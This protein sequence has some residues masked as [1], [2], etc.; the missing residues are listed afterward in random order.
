MSGKISVVINTLNEEK[1]I[2]RAV[3]SVKWADEII[4]CDMHSDDETVKIA[5]S[6]GA[7]VILHKKV[8]YV[9]PARNF[10]ISKAMG[11]WILI[12]DADEKIPESL[13]KRLQELVRKRISS[14]F[15]EIPR[16]NII[17]GKWLKHTGWWPDYHIRFFK[18]GKVVWSDKIH[19][20]P[21]TEGLRLTLPPEDRFAIVHHNYQSL[22]QFLERMNRYSEIE[23][24][25][26]KSD[27]YKFRWQDLISK[28]LDEF[29]SRFFANKGY[30]DGLHGLVL[31]MLQAFSFFVVYLKLW[32]KNGF[33]EQE[34]AVSEFEREV[35]KVGE[36]VK[37]WMGQSR[38]GTIKRFLKIFKK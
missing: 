10:A 32:E 35:K 27:G 38:G 13:S 14:D 8:G 21:K 11:D 31:S 20:K 24:K 1:N 3:E 12:L 19:S 33:K 16:K 30:E 2:K 7:K 9:E 5:K 34:L 15:V 23:A 18:K 6:L 36:D 26:L 22:S 28:P 25:E 37:Y 4:V 17:F 29:L